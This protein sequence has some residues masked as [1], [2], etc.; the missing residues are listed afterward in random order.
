MGQSHEELSAG[1]VSCCEVSAGS[2]HWLS[3][4]SVSGRLA[5]FC[6]IAFP[7][8]SFVRLKLNLLLSLS[9]CP[10][11]WTTCSLDFPCGPLDLPLVCPWPVYCTSRL[12]RKTY[13]FVF[14]FW[15][16]NFPALVPSRL[17]CL[18]PFTRRCPPP[19]CRATQASEASSLIHESSSNS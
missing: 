17:P 4:T 15:F 7:S 6:G 13:S 16:T 10:V 14:H 5:C 8:G 1:Q 12:E 11:D 3:W 19:K 18:E 9:C 2:N